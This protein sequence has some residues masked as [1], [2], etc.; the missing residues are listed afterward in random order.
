VRTAKRQAVACGVDIGST[1]TKV[2]ALT[3]D[4]AV[5]SH[6]AR[7]TPRDVQTLS[8]DPYALLDVIDQMLS[9]TCGDHYA[10]HTI[11]V[12]GIGED[13]MLVDADLH[14]LSPPLSWFDPRRQGIFKDL[15]PHLRVDDTLDVVGDPTH[16]L[17][18]WAW[19]RHQSGAAAA[20]AW[21]AVADFPSVL[22][23]GRTFLSD[24]LASRTGAWR[25]TD[26]SWHNDRVELTLGSVVLLPPVAA[27]GE[28]IGELVS[29]VLRSAGLLA[30][31]AVVVAGGHDHPIGGWGVDQLVPGVILD[32]MGTA[33]VAVV[34]S[35]RP[36]PLREDAVDLA[37]GIRSAGATLLRVEEITRNVEWATQDPVVARHIRQILTG[38]VPPLP[39][40]DSGFFIPGQ[41]GGGRPAYAPDAPRDARARASAVL[42]ALAGIGRDA[43]VALQH[44]A[45]SG[46]D[47]RLAGGWSRYPGWL[48]IKAAINGIP[49]VPIAEPEVTAVGAALLAAAGRGWRPEPGRALA[50]PVT[51]D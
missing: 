15:R 37:P 45:R 25:S 8:I 27:A 49:A 5:V 2:V 40:L 50:G 28:I 47:V 38:E 6:A 1:N 48:E 43:V 16:T 20:A 46:R 13:G 22:W 23:T 9:E 30:S 44:S 14:P 51:T 33:E 42:G 36:R 29:P 3:P 41:R 34:Q 11:C 12:A 32:S 31:D 4:G 35:S 26:R 17:V 18:G 19:S 10:I 7:P 39:V 24:T 21:L